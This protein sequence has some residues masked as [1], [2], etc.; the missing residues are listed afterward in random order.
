MVERRRQ[1]QHRAPDDPAA[2]RTDKYLVA[3]AYR[4]RSTRL[5]AQTAG[6]LGKHDEQVHYDRM[7]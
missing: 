1:R 3:T 2:S 4:I 6:L 5:L 7:A